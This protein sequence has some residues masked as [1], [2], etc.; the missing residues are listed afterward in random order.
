MG[1]LESGVTAIVPG[2]VAASELV[3]R[4]RAADPGERMPPADSGKTLSS[5]EIA[6]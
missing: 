1:K 6:R 3:R 5:A 4:I 2:D